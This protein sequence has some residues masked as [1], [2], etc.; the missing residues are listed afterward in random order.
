M[1]A[2]TETRGL[3]LKPPEKLPST[4]VSKVA[5]KV[6]KNQLIAFLEQDIVNHMFLK[7]GRYSTWTARQQ[8]RR[9]T[10][11]VA[12]DPEM[13]K[14]RKEYTQKQDED[15][16]DEDKEKL[17]TLRNSQ[18]ARFVQLIAVLTYY[19]E[20]DDIDQCSTNFDWIIRYLE[21]HYGIESRGAHFMDIST[22]VFKKGTQHQTFYK[23]F[24]AG[25]MDNLRKKGD[26]L[27]YKND[28]LLK[29]D[30]KM[31]PTLESTIVLWA[32][33]RVDP[34]LPLKVKKLYGHQMVSNKCLV[35]LQP[36]IFQNIT[37]M[38]HELD[39]TDQTSNSNSIAAEGGD[40]QLNRLWASRGGGRGRGSSGGSSGGFRNGRPPF[41]ASRSGGA[42]RTAGP[43]DNKKPFCR[44]CYLAGSPEFVFES[45]GI[46]QCTKLSTADKMDL[47]IKANVSAGVVTEVQEEQEPRRDDYEAPGWD[48][49]EITV[50]DNDGGING[51]SY[52]CSSLIIAPVQLNTISPIASQIMNTMHFSIIFP[53][54]LDS[55]AT[56]SFVREREILAMKIKVHQNGQLATLADEKTRMA[57]K[58][59]IDIEVAIHGIILRLRALVMENLQ[60]ICFGGD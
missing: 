52:M 30:E 55:G 56:V 5:F 16:F 31:S 17:L 32:L 7:D 34:R 57:S 42:T 50:N 9:V 49:E 13:I 48:V 11:I 15:K 60:A 4:G 22:L 59:E 1:M 27:E 38:L 2:G 37:T 10:N 33:E 47:G 24:R 51:G 43:R 53:I 39:E 54:T 19:T 44:M 6:F 26:K 12:S 8:G 28:E 14:I 3:Y 36:T 45:Q 58:G 29:E 35:T 40:G 23:Q 20:Q 25:F 18:C 41:P 21:K 46:S